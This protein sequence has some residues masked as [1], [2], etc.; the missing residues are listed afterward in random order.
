VPIFAANAI[1]GLELAADGALARSLQFS[2]GMFWDIISE[3]ISLGGKMIK[4]AGFALM[5]A[6]FSMALT[7]A[8]PVPE[9]DPATG[10][11]TLALIAG[12]LLVLRGRR[13]K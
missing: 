6:A 1:P 9:I 8:P 11:S 13:K 7:A 4:I 3:S 12:A 5:F 10:A 2:P